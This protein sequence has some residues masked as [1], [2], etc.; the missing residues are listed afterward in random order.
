MALTSILTGMNTFFNYSK[1]QIQ[2]YEFSGKS[3]RLSTEIEKERAKR[4][5]DRLAAD[6]FIERIPMQ[7]N[8][9]VFNSPAL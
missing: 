6:V 7:Y 9:L 5:K 8:D 2:H 4:K 3:F 1:K